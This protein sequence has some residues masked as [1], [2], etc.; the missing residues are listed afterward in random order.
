[1][2]REPFAFGCSSNTTG[3]FASNLI[4]NNQEA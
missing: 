4:K 1:M 2:K 3:I